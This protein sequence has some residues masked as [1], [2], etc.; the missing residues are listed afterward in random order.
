MVA[1]ERFTWKGLKEDVLKHVCKSEACQWNKVELIHPVGLL[2]PL[3]IPEGN[4]ETILMDFITRLPTV[5]RK[6]CIYVVL[7]SLTKFT[8]F[9]SIPYWLIGAWPKFRATF[10]KQ[11]PILLAISARVYEAKTEVSPDVV[12]ECA[13]TRF[14][15][16][17]YVWWVQVVR[18]LNLCIGCFA[19]FPIPWS[20]IYYLHA[21]LS[22]G[23]SWRSTLLPK[24]LMVFQFQLIIL[25]YL[26]SLSYTS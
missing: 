15:H 1:Q 5:Q 18:G 10:P 9:F 14:L 4:W 20:M 22:R 26:C 17:I 24:T 3:P 19:H 25:S 16:P 21:T 7:D 13:R 11:I 6:D 8:H 12:R 23:W 2:Q